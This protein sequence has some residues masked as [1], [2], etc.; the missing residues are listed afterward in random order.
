MNWFDRT[1]ARIR[2]A[3]AESRAVPAA[4]TRP[5]SATDFMAW[6]AGDMFATSSGVAVT[7]ESALGVPAVWAAVNFLSGTLAGLPLKIYRKTRDGREVMSGQLADMLHYAPN[8]EMSSFEWRKLFFDCVFTTGRGLAYIERGASGAPLHIWHLDP[9]LVTIERRGGKKFYIYA[10]PGG[11]RIEYAGADVIDV[12][13]M[14]KADGLQ[15]RGP[16]TQCRDAIGQAIAANAY[17]QRY[18]ANGGVPPFVVTGG[19]QSVQAMA[20]AREDFERAV[21]EGAKDRRQ[22]LV[23]PD[24]LKVEPMGGDPEKAQLVELQRFCIEQV[25][26][27]WQLSPVFLQDLTHGTMSNTEQQDL[28]FTKHTV[29][30]WVEQFEQEL[31]LK[32]FGVRSNSRYV[33][34][35]MDGLMRGDIRSRYEAY[36]TAIQHGFM[37]PATAMEMENMPAPDG[38]DQ[39]FMQGAMLPITEVGAAGA[40]IPAA[41]EQAND[42]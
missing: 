37:K 16:I 26:R 14:L 9:M 32:L 29:K 19:F 30:R 36:A 2:G 20:Q 6:L 11:Q 3:G 15:H 22:A 39:L 5:Q 41:E 40:R 38:A 25:A 10:P 8:P 1:M 13:F 18:L 24:G 17:G 27:V 21:R 35:S 33:E 4:S 42:D 31:N 28:Q 12:P 34:F 7:T 23:L